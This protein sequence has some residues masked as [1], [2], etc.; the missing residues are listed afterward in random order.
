MA[1]GERWVLRR[2]LGTAG[3]TTHSVQRIIFHEFY[4]LFF[5]R[6]VPVAQASRVASCPLP[7][8]RAVRTPRR[9]A[10]NT[11]FSGPP[12]GRRRNVCLICMVSVVHEPQQACLSD[13]GND[14]AAVT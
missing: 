9:Q 8:S 11:L 12:Y 2:C 6:P 13:P 7:F 5:C 3:V 14:S 4:P 10:R 1:G